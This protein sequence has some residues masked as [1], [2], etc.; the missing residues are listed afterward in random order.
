MILVVGATGMLGGLIAAQLAGR[1]MAVRAMCRT[2][3]EV[4]ERLERLTSS[5][6]TLCPGDLKDYDSV[7]A[8]CRGAE[9][10]V[11]TASATIS[12]TPG[13]SIETVDLQGQ[14]N[15]VRAARAT[16]VKHFV[17]ISFAPTPL[18]SALQTAKRTVELELQKSGITYTILQPTF[19]A[20]I[21]L[22]PFLGFDYTQG[23][24]TA[25]GSGETKTSWISIQDVAA[26]AVG[27]LHNPKAYGRVLQ[28]GGPA[29][30]SLLDVVRI[31]EQQSGRQ[32]TVTRVPLEALM[33]KREGA[34]DSLEHSTM[35]LL[36]GCAQGQVVDMTEALS[37]VPLPLRSVEHYAREAL[38]V[39]TTG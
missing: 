1:K 32:F 33:A 38:S 36:I 21:W 12:R 5:G 4:T 22:S 16:G 7:E 20:E 14:L 28:L 26:F 13:D 27:S 11:S 6:I 35:S 2:R 3:P 15:L 8:A 31:F 9:A 18:D 29:S 24:V 39:Q 23:T 17:F 19:F 34:K 37:V 25:Y 10:V 30:L